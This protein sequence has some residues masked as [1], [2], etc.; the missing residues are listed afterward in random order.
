MDK[1]TKNIAI[2]LAVAAVVV[3][4]FF[5]RQN[6]I[7][8]GELDDFA[9]C[10]EQ[11]SEKFYGAFWCPHCQNQKSAFGS[12]QK[13]LPYVECSTQDSKGQLPVCRDEEIKAYPTW[14]FHDGVTV[15]GELSLKELSEK[16]GCPLPS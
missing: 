6:N 9:K 16:S 2:G 4:A 14:K 1:K 8:P 7:R 5:W 3:I 15:Q 10:L 12:S 13:Y 11:K